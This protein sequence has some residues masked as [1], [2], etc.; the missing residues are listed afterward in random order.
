[1]GKEKKIEKKRGPPRLLPEVFG[2]YSPR[3][4]YLP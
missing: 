1:M 4:R 3:K 2:E